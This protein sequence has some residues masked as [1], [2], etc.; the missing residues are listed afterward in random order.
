[1]SEM[2]TIELPD[3][4]AERVRK[5]A[6]GRPIESLLT[7]WI[8]QAVSD[9]NLMSNAPYPIYTPYGNEAAAKVLSDYLNTFEDTDPQGK[10]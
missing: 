6:Q 5:L 8:E 4:L 3:E 10:T 7:E 1:M 9:M 2:I